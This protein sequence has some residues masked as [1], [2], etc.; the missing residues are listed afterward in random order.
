MI[1]IVG[2]FNDLGTRAAG[3]MCAMEQRRDNPSTEYIIF[4]C[5]DE[6]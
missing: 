5:L 2:E 3:K 1:N 4:L 6:M